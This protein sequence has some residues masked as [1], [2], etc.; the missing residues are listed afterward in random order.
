MDWSARKALQ[1]STPSMRGII[2]SLTI[3]VTSCS[4]S[5]SNA[6]IPSSAVRMEYW[7]EKLLERKFSISSLSSTISINGLFLEDITGKVSDKISS[8]IAG[9]RTPASPS[10]TSAPTCSIGNVTMKEEPLLISDSTS[11]QPLCDSTMLFTMLSPIPVP[12]LLSIA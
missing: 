6:S 8:G 2:Q 11:M 4:F 10:C 1:N 12:G 7:A 5:F 9:L 3:K